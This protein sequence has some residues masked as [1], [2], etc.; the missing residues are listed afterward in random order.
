MLQ[1]D[2]VQQ[3]LQSQPSWEQL[4]QTSEKIPKGKELDWFAAGP[5]LQWHMAAAL[6]KPLHSD[7]EACGWLAHPSDVI[8]TAAVKA[9]AIDQDSLNEVRDVAQQKCDERKHRQAAGILLRAAK[10]AGRLQNRQAVLQ[11]NGSD[12]F[13]DICKDALAAIDLITQIDQVS[14]DLEVQICAAVVR[15]LV[16]PSNPFFDVV[17]ERLVK[18]NEDDSFQVKDKLVL[19]NIFIGK[20]FELVG[21][22]IPTSQDNELPGD[23]AKGYL[24]CRKW[25]VLVRKFVTVRVR[26]PHIYY[27]FM[28]EIS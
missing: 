9:I 6:T 19:A 1:R 12:R 24:C 16:R 25:A 22:F 8:A 7:E 2:F 28:D 26:S 3:L 27:I 23:I 11:N 21:Y 4:P 13:V 15:W 14:F 5:G 18:L 17:V 10:A 20:S